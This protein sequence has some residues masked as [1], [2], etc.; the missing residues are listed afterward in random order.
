M[1]TKKEQKE[2]ERTEAIAKL[3]E[4]LP[5]GSTVH[6]VVKHVSRSGMSRSIVPI[7][8]WD[9]EPTDVSW[10]VARV[11]DAKV[12]Q[13]NGGVK[14]G[15]CGMDMGFHLVSTL[16][17]YLYPDGFGCIGENGR[18]RCPSNDHS[19]GDRDYT[20]HGGKV[21]HWHRSGGYALR[22]KWL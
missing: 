16:S 17:Y 21:Q 22:H 12:D 14:V 8:V 2:Q 11:L 3:R 19:N 1:A 4:L 18:E 13:R 6:T 15:G 5:P 9:G 20:P 7:I 10:L